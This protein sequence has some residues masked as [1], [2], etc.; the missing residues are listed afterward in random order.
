LI[1]TKKR[2]N[3]ICAVIPFFN[4]EKYLNQ[5]V[6]G[7]SGF[8]DAIIAVDDGS[9]DNSLLCLNNIPGITVLKIS[10]N[11]GKGYALQQGF[12]KCIEE[13]FDVVITIDGDGQ[14]KPEYIPLLLNNIET[15]DIVIGNRLNNV[16]SMPFQ[17]RLSNRLTS[18]FLSK[19]L[20]VNIS[21]SQCGFRAYKIQVLSEVKTDMKGFEAESQMLVKAVRKN[22]SIG[23]VDIPTIYADEK[24]KMKS[25]QAIKGFIK[26]LMS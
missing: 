14:H 10:S 25:F 24:S 13:G 19:K 4:E 16:S 3:K 8:V 23:F 1:Y 6:Q 2:T 15:F 5:V 17:R 21:D 26:V 18:Y 7:T 12:N 11:T 20:G 9:T 22:F